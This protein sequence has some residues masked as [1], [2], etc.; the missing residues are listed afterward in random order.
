MTVGLV[1][2]FALVSRY[3]V[4]VD[5]RVAVAAEVDHSAGALIGFMD[6]KAWMG[7]RRQENSTKRFRHMRFFWGKPQ[8]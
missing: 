5:E 7:G 6:K 8:R 3:L 2:V 1:L 4:S